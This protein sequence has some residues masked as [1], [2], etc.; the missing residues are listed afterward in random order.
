MDGIEIRA[1]IDK[2]QKI[3]QSGINKFI[4]NK[5]IA[6]ALQENDRL[7]KI[8]THKFENG[9]CIYCDTQEKVD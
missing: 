9:F 8:C 3:I 4:L 1:I 2:N 7:R 6:A 5:E